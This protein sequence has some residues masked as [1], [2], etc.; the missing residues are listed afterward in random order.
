MEVTRNVILDLL[1]LYLADEASK[2]SRKLVEKYL[3]KDAELAEMAKN[4]E[5]ATLPE[6]IPISLTEEGKMEAYR[7]AKRLMLVRTVV[8]SV[9]I[10]GSIITVLLLGLLAAGF[11]LE[12]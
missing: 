6:N 8:L 4:P 10:S 7:E 12:G 5:A 11:F 3:E 2:D 1:P 9:I